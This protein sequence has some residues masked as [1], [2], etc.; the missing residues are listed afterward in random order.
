MPPKT[1]SNFSVVYL[2]NESLSTDERIVVVP[3]KYIQSDKV[4]YM[5]FP[6]SE[7]DQD[8]IKSF[9]NMRAPPPPPSA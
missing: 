8:S 7:D 5:E 6:L 9:L 1:C 4:S 2:H 3:V